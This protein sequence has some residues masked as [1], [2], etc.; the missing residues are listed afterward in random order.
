MLD[1]LERTG[2]VGCLCGVN[3]PKRLAEL[4]ASSKRA[5]A[6]V[7]M[8]SFRGLCLGPQPIVGFGVGAVHHGLVL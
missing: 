5:R 3:V 6:R 8:P 2:G 7:C 1:A 4:H